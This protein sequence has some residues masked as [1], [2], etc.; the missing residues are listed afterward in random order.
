[1]AMAPA[2]QF[3]ILIHVCTLNVVAMGNAA[4]IPNFSSIL[5]FW[6]STVDTGNNNCIMTFIHFSHIDLYDLGC[7]KIGVAGLSPIGQ[8]NGK[9]ILLKN[10]TGILLSIY[11]SRDPSPVQSLMG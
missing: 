3:I 6:D 5:V 10:R 1:M 4:F 9:S 8:Y 11:W 7:G 2:I